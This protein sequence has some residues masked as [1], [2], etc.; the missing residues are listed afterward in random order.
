[1]LYEVI[2]GQSSFNFDPK[3][4]SLDK[5]YGSLMG[6]DITFWWK[7][8]GFATGLRYS[9]YNSIRITSYNVCYTKL[10]RSNEIV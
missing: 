6:A 7:D 10:L 9:T 2:T 8:L 5:G 3:I 1:M 4:G